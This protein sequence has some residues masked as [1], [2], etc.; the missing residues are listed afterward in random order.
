MQEMKSFNTFKE[1]G[2]Y[3][4]KVR[5]SKNEKLAFISRQL[6]IKKQILQDLE[7]GKISATE[8]AANSHLKGFL[9]SYIRY[10]NLENQLRLD[11]VLKQKPTSVK[12][13]NVSLEKTKERKNIYGSM[14]ILLSL[15]LIC[16]TYLIWNKNTYYHLYK[17]GETLN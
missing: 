1:L 15:I 14:M 10:L 17:L 16:I 4:K 6:I 5:R 9:N 2:S 12:N 8:F 11:A 3:I 13:R 7:E